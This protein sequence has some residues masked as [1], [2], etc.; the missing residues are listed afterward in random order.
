MPARDY[1]TYLRE[2]LRDPELA[3][4]YLTA[5]LEEDRPEHF[6][7]ALRNVSAAHGGRNDVAD[8]PTLES[9]VSVL[10][11]L[12]LRLALSPRGGAAA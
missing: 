4:E 1:D 9:L 8:D 2:Q 6:V 10:R 7:L 3:A 11:A 5:A 12:G